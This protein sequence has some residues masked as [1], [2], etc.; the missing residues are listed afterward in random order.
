[1][2]SIGLVGMSLCFAVAGVLQAYLERYL[3][4]PYIISQQPIRFWMLLVFL[5]GLLVLGGAAHVAMHLL[6]LRP[7]PAPR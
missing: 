7:P 5:H 4:Q 6:R 2:M 3:G 1:M